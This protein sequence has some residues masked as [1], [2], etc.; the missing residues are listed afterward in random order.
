MSREINRKIR[1]DTFTRTSSEDR[2][3]Q[4]VENLPSPT[5]RNISPHIIVTLSFPFDNKR[6]IRFTQYPI[7]RYHLQKRF[8]FSSVCFTEQSSRGRETR[9]DLDAPIFPAE[10]ST[11]PDQRSRETDSGSELDPFRFLLGSFEGFSW[12]GAFGGAKV[13][14]ARV[15]LSLPVIVLVFPAAGET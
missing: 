9:D 7:L 1:T 6:I 2:L 15:S 12:H 8:S 3:L 13:K 11:D 14:L 4:F 10:G 5:F